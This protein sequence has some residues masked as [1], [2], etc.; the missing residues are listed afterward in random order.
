M[1]CFNNFERKK[2]ISQ[3]IFPLRG[4][5]IHEFHWGAMR[6]KIAIFKQGNSV[7]RGTKNFEWRNFHEFHWV[8]MRQKMAIFKRGNSVWRGTK[9]FELR[10][11]HEFHRG[12]MRQKMAIFKQGNSVWRVQKFLN[13]IFVNGGDVDENR[14]FIEGKLVAHYQILNIFEWGRC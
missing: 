11:F 6:Q 3:K 1:F 9:I 10:K 4:P 8:A 14:H 7:W 2:H 5:F 13:D 12:A